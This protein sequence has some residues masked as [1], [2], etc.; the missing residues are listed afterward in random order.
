MVDTSPGRLNIHDMLPQEH[1]EQALADLFK[2]Y[3]TVVHIFTALQSESQES[4]PSIS[5]RYLK[6]FCAKAGI[7]SSSA[8]AGQ[9]VPSFEALDRPSFLAF[10]VWAWQQ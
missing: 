5:L 3:E 6:E 9:G 2:N 10:V 1:L 7:L 4:Y 8:F